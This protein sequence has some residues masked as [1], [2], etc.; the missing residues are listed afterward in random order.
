MFYFNDGREMGGRMS[1]EEPRLA[2]LMQK[3]FVNVDQ[4]Q[5]GWFGKDKQQRLLGVLRNTPC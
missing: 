4:W 1:A 2:Q 3:G 5:K